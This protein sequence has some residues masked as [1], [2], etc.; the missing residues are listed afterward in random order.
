[1]TYRASPTI[2]LITALGGKI[3]TTVLEM[4]KFSPFWLGEYSNTSV[5]FSYHQCA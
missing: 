5:V 3:V 2:D 4:R 1:M